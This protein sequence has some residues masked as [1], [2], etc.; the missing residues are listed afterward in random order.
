MIFSLKSQITQKLLI[1]FFLNKTTEKYV[2]ELAKILVVDP[3][4]L[5][6]KLKELTRA[7]IFK[8]DRRGKE[9]FYSL[10]KNFT[11]LKEYEQIVKKTFG[12]ERQIKNILQNE[13]NICKAYIFGSYAKNKLGTESDIDLLIIGNQKLL[14]LQVKFFA[15][16]KQIG[17][18]INI[19]NMT[20][21]EFERKKQNTN[22]FI[23]NIFTRPII[24]II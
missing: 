10:N 17:R 23:K 3:K 8:Q 13:K 6:S 22:P 11:L 4:N 21:A 20:K 19:I 15:L 7:G 18:E 2:N 14:D 24:E 1:Y 9:C 16:Q 5:D 12:I